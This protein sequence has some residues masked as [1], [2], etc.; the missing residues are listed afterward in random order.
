MGKKIIILLADGFEEVEALTPMDY[1]LRAG[2]ELTLAAVGGNRNVK[3]ARGLTIVADTTLAD[4]S[5]SGKLNPSHWDG[6]VVPGG[7]PG[8]ANIAA[9]M[10]A[11]ALL[12]GAFSAGRLV[13]AIC[14]APAL[15]LAP[16][17][18][19]AGRRFTCYPGMEKDVAGALWSSDRVVVDGHIITSRAA[20]TAGEWSMA[21]IA[22]LLGG[23]AA[24][25]VAGAVLLHQ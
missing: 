3:S 2:A 11:V 7:M 21:I 16:Q 13:A 14:A 20:G 18:I 6:V 1:L 23:D 5:S 15:V 25:K 19:L 8:A 9:S 24:K 10:T 4:L 22:A 17:G 12:K